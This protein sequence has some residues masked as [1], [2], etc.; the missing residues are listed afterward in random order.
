MTSAHLIKK[1]HQ[2]E[3][4]LLARYE[5]NGRRYVAK[6]LTP[7]A[8]E[9]ASCHQQL[10]DEHQFLS[11][12]CHDRLLNVGRFDER[13]GLLL[14]DDAT[15]TLRD[16][17]SSEG[18]MPNDL[19]CNVVIE[20]CELLDALHRQR[21]LH[22]M[23]GSDTVFVT[24]DGHIKS[25]NFVGY[26]FDIGDPPILARSSPRYEAPEAIDGQSDCGP[27]TDLYCVGFLALEMLTGAEFPHLFGL[28]ESE[29]DRKW[30]VWHDDPNKSLGDW[31]RKVP[32]AAG[33]LVQLINGLIEK[34]VSKRNPETARA[35]IEFINSHGLQSRKLLQTSA[36]RTSVPT[37]NKARVQRAKKRKYRRESPL[38]S[39]TDAETGEVCSS[40]ATKPL[41]L[42]SD[43]QTTE[44]G[45]RIVTSEFKGVR[46]ALLSPGAGNWMVFD[47]AT[48]ASVRVNDR[49]VDTTEPTILNDNDRLAIG[50]RILKVDFEYRGR[51][52][53]PNIEL[54][55]RIH[56]GSGG[57]L[58]AAR[59][60]RRNGSTDPVAL[61]MY[62][63]EFTLDEDQIR[64]FMRSIPE[65]SLV[66]HPN[67]VR[68]HR[69]GMTRD[70]HKT[71]WYLASELMRTSLRDAMQLAGGPLR[72][73]D[74]LRFGRE[75]ATALQAAGERGIVHRN[76]TPSAIL[77]SA[78]M[79]A[80]LGDFSLS[81][82]EI[83]ESIFD[84]TRGPLQ[85]QDY[86]YQPPEIVA[87]KEPSLASDLYSLVVCMY[88]A[89]THVMPIPKVKSF[90]GQ[91]EEVANFKWPDV[92]EF[93]P[94]VPAA[95]A[96][97]FDRVLNKRE[98]LTAESL[99]AEI[100]QFVDSPG[101]G[102]KLVQS[103]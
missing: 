34:D 75:I 62:S 51:G 94:E 79:R 56:Q 17:I 96:R 65:A 11:Q 99:I 40:R 69:G 36:G 88:E 2:S 76:L 8:L 30:L 33:A 18:A 82:G 41:V 89:V 57:D 81:R 102:R 46:H 49:I 43:P 14:F 37:S 80:K 58:Y 45:V 22:G 72:R 12:I 47:L 101:D 98:I 32:G 5:E 83:Q 27:H 42:G 78:N 66:K 68:L 4:A 6:Q 93:N 9:S 21:L 55:G 52:V 74:I 3:T 39:L 19:V 95:L 59:L 92:R 38:M 53:I 48:D 15:C 44:C 28:T 85:R 35:V 63:Q 26:R 64:R 60:F 20:L 71:T 24:A 70:R 90:A 86:R 103:A 54:L 97:L 84:L 67:V 25:G 87:G 1:L 10:A 91:L 29:Q 50:G 77:F 13:K 100:N 73:R 7:K 31:D 23:I 61:R 16:Y